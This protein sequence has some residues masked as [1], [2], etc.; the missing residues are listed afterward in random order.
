MLSVHLLAYS[1]WLVALFQPFEVT[2]H[3]AKACLTNF[4]WSVN[5]FIFKT[6]TE[7]F[8]HV[9][10]NRYGCCVLQCCLKMAQYDQYQLL[11]KHLLDDTVPLCKAI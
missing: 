7:Y 3:H 6:I 2:L 1:L 9:A 4:S 11:L 5:D 10:N 8:I